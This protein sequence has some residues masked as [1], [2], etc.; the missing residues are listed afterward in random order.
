RMESLLLSPDTLAAMAEAHDQRPLVPRNRAV[1]E[2]VLRPLRAGREVR[3]VVLV[4][5]ELGPRVGGMETV[6]RALAA[7]LLARGIDVRVYA[8][9][10][11]GPEASGLPQGT[12]RRLYTPGI[13]LWSDLLITLDALLVDAPD[14]VHLCNAGLGPWVPALA[15]AFP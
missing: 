3:R 11:F 9:R 7:G 1:A 12:V 13:D 6:A 2:A 10:Y 4:A 5:H 8:T 15:A 14:V